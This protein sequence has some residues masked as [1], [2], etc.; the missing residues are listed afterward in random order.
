MG[1]HT[2]DLTA[3]ERAFYRLCAAFEQA[4]TVGLHL[5]AALV[6]LALMTLAAAGCLAA[7]GLL[8]DVAG[9]L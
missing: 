9:A 7:I 1:R 2:S 5:V 3:F 6:V 4:C 8:A